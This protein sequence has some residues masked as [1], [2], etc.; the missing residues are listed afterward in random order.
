M[1]RA[2][3]LLL[4]FLLGTGAAT[5]HPTIRLM[6]ESLAAEG[7]S[8]P[9]ATVK[10]AS[11]KAPDIPFHEY[12]FQAEQDLLQLANQSRRQVGV[13]PLK[14]D[15]GLSEA[16]RT[17]AIAM[18]DARQLTRF[19]LRPRHRHQSTDAGYFDRAIRK[20]IPSW[21]RRTPGTQTSAVRDPDI[22]LRR[23]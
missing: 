12:E 19:I 10:T 20:S 23:V 6:A 16:A 21:S 22:P 18:M 4:A 13:G 11:A 2:P 9:Q 1:H 7:L 8:S 14:L 5:V 3:R 15:S 17:H